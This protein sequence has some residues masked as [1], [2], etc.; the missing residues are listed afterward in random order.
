MEEL[1]KRGF[2]GL[3]Y[4]EVYLKFLHFRTESYPTLALDTNHTYNFLYKALKSPFSQADVSRTRSVLCHSCLCCCLLPGLAEHTH[5]VLGRA[6]HL[7]W[8]IGDLAQS[9]SF[10]AV[11]QVL[12]M[13]LSRQWGQAP[14]VAVACLHGGPVPLSG[15]S[16][17]DGWK[18]EPL[19]PWLKPSLTQ[20]THMEPPGSPL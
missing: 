10:T 4:L 18:G 7:G 16:Q 20:T 15:T 6:A 3:I 12:W 13:S 17:P 14:L 11:W 19:T 1:V 8:W 9:R 2:E 5:A